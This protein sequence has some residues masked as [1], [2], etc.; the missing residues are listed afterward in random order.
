MTRLILSASM[1]T[2]LETAATARLRSRGQRFT[3]RRRALVEILAEVGQPLTLPE[4]LAARHGFAQSSAYR[5]LVVLEQAGVVHRLVTSTDFARYELAEDL[6]KHH[7]H[8]VCVQCG[9]MEDFAAPSGMERSV[10]AAVSRVAG[11]HGFTPISHRLD[12]SGLCRRCAAS[13]ASG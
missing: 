5:N 7:H 9:A 8:L 13:A 3:P 2:D 4:I 11:E 1:P 12:V 10:R 6:T